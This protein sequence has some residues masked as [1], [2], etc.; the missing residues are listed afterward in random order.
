[1]AAMREKSAEGGT[2]GEHGNVP[3]HSSQQSTSADQRG[4][5][6]RQRPQHA[7][8]SPILKEFLT[9]FFSTDVG[10]SWRLGGGGSGSTC[11]DPDPTLIRP[12]PITNLFRP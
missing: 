4:H 2:S 1:M 7:R 10:L 8:G 9:H 6:G 12:P 3:Q 11:F 5:G